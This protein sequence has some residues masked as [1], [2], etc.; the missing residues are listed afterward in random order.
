M[1][2]ASH[3]ALARWAAATVRESYGSFQVEF[4]H[5]TRRA[6]LR[7]EARDWRGAHEDA[8]ER[9]DLHP[10]WI[11]RT[12]DELRGVLGAATSNPLLGM[13][14]KRNFEQELAGLPDPELARTFY[15]SIVRRILGTVGV[16]ARAEF[17]AG[18]PLPRVER[19]GS[20]NHRTYPRL[21][22][23]EALAK[24]VLTDY[25]FQTPYRDLKADARL[26]GATLD[27][28]VRSSDDRRPLDAIEMLKPVFYRGKGAYLVGRLCRGG[29]V[30]PFILALLHG[31]QGVFVDAAL[32]LPQ[33]ASVVFSFTRSYF[34]VEAEGTADLIAFL[35]S[36]LPQKP[37]SELYIA[38]GYDKHGKTA[39][40]RELVECLARTRD[41][42]E[43]ARGDRGMVMIVFTLP[44]LDVVFKVIRDRFQPP[45]S[46]TRKEVMQKYALVFRHDRAGRLVDAQEFEHLVFER[47]RFSG[48]VLDEL[49]REA[50]ETVQVEGER[51]FIRHLYAERR[52]TPLNLF[53]R[54]RDEGSAREA[55]LDYGQALRD[56]AATNTFP[57]DLLLKN[58]GVTRS[59]RVI[60]YDYDEL[61]LVTDCNFRDIPRGADDEDD[62]RGEPWFYVGDSD[63]FPEEFFAFLGLPENLRAGFLE[64]HSEILTA[65]FW[66]RM[67]D[68]HRAGEIVDIFPYKESRRLRH[69]PP[70]P[71]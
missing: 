59:G 64:A 18:E 21:G 42:F 9:L 58:F 32:T 54:E 7:F 46:I 67:Q 48:E 56:L 40:Y 37:M 5:I 22:S 63:V 23:A 44:S 13:Q 11:A 1:L 50:S 35:K 27:A 41:R 51:V 8:L 61:C 2:N 6:K 4:R 49:S 3:A 33:D 39:L 15:N 69:E 36:I 26:V 20:P 66:R 24:M 28:L 53:I 29:T 52:V 45:K 38:I 57:G 31:D 17:V 60:F 25:A 12:V 68:R 47:A 55:L 16:N 10:R 65:D 43:R 14:L 30:S 62:A 70:S 19:V 71:D 34:H